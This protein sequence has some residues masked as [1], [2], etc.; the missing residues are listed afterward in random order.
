MTS[1]NDHGKPYVFKIVLKIDLNLVL[2]TEECIDD[3][4]NYIY[5]LS[6]V[7]S[8]VLPKIIGTVFFSILLNE[9]QV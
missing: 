2:S 1:A 6:Y 3:I 8:T 9:I 7:H 5:L 4:N